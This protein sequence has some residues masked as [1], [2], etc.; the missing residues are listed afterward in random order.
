MKWAT[1]ELI[2]FDR[3][4]SAWLILRFI[5]PDA[6]F[7]FLKADET[8]DSEALLFGVPGARFAP[9]DGEVTTFERIR[10]GHALNDAA[11]AKL[12]RI[13]AE[14]CRPCHARSVAGGFTQ[15]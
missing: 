14:T 4:A 15:T 12:S 1:R 10:D 5:D 2:H 3:I 9:H 6:R 11:L 7:I 8:P 13:V